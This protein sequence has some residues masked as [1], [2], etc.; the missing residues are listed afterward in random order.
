MLF[1]TPKK[2]HIA[3]FSGALLYD[4]YFQ[5]LIWPDPRLLLNKPCEFQAAASARCSPIFADILTLH[6]LGIEILLIFVGVLFFRLGSRGGKTE[7]WI[8]TTNV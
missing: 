1:F 8:I 4:F 2:V 5:L 3:Q 6:A 7:L